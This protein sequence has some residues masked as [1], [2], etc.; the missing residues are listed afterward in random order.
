MEPTMYIWD[1]RPS[2]TLQITGVQ[3]IGRNDWIE[4]NP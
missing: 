3:A 4:S 1:G 2:P